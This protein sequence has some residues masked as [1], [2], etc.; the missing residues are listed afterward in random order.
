LSTEASGQSS[1]P[2]H[3]DSQTCKDVDHVEQV[4]FAPGST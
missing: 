4:I 1:I 3:I 2:C